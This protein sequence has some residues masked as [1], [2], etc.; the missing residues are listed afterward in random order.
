MSYLSVRL[1][2]AVA[3]VTVA[4]LVGGSTTERPQ[5]EEPVSRSQP[6]AGQAKPVATTP[7][8]EPSIL[9]R[10]RSECSAPIKG[11]SAS[12]VLARLVKEVQ[13]RIAEQQ[14]SMLTSGPGGPLFVDLLAAREPAGDMSQ[15]NVADTV[16]VIRTINDDNDVVWRVHLPGYNKPAAR[17]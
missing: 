9:D 6:I 4:V 15:L 17:G 2:H 8:Q 5:P 13:P 14:V 3:V 7:K 10:L 16:C 12:H 11:E 1:I